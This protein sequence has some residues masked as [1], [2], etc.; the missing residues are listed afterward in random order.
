MGKARPDG[1]TAFGHEQA[2]T[3][4]FPS[5]IGPFLKEFVVFEQETARGLHPKQ[6]IT[7]SRA[8]LSLARPH[9][10]DDDA[11]TLKDVQPDA[12]PGPRV[13]PRLLSS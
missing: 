6:K 9:A 4:R 10:R 13:V 11:Q 12:P 3:A 8:R 2:K 5:F 7:D 1:E